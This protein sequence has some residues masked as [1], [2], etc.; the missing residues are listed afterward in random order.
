MQKKREMGSI[1]GADDVNKLAEKAI[2]II[3][4][5]EEAE[6]EKNNLKEKEELTQPRI[7]IQ[8]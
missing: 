6:E 3:E 5:P 8:I 7:N 4:H 2:R 1:R